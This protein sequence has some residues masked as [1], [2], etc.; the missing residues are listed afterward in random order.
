MEECWRWD[1]NRTEVNWRGEQRY[2]EEGVEWNG[3]SQRSIGNLVSNN[4]PSSKAEPTRL[5]T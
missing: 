2:S 5:I 1:G 4:T 3:L